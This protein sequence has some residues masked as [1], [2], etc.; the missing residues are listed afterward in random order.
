MSSVSGISQAAT[1]IANAQ[2]QNKVQ[3]A[4]MR[5]QQEASQQQG[6]AAV[7]LIQA[8]ASIGRHQDTLELSTH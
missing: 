8:A 1:A 5:K 6:D 2:T 3:I 4:V 7:K